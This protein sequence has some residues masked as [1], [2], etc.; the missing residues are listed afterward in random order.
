M[1]A[2]AVLLVL[3]G[4]GAENEGTPPTDTDQAGACAEPVYFDASVTGRVTD[5]GAP[6]EGVEVRIEERNWAPGTLHGSGS[7]GADGRFT[8][9]ATGLP[10]IEGCWGWATG[11]YVVAQRGTG[12]AEWGINSL[13]VSAWQED[14]PTVDLAGISLD[15]GER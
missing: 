3:I 11:F 14:A 13:I 9:E 8:F 10:I 5:G 15:V 7:T 1:R 6:A 4:C 12:T 2:I